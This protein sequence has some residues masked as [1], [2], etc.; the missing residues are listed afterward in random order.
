MRSHGAL[1]GTL[2]KAL[3]KEHREFQEAQSLDRFSKAYEMTNSRFALSVLCNGHSRTVRMESR[4]IPAQEKH[5]QLGERRSREPRAK[6][7]PGEGG[8]QGGP[9]GR[10]ACS[11]KSGDPPSFRTRQT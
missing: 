1:K 3:M 2:C 9:D 6:V 5:H 4:G 10:V 7:T 8:A 11:D